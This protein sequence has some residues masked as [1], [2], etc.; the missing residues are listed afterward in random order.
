MV[1]ARKQG[2]EGMARLLLKVCWNK[3]ELTMTFTVVHPEPPPPLA[4]AGQSVFSGRDSYSLILD[5]AGVVRA[6]GGPA[7]EAERTRLLLGQD[8]LRQ[9]RTFPC[10]KAEIAAVV[11]QGVRDL[12]A[13]RRHQ[14]ACDHEC[15][16]NPG[17]PC[18]RITGVRLDG[19]AGP[20][21]FVQ[22]ENVSEAKRN[23]RDLSLARFT[24][25]H[26]ADAIF[27]AGESGGFEYVNDQACA[28]LGY[29]A[30]ELLKLSVWDVDTSMTRD[31]WKTAWEKCRTES[32][33]L[34][35]SSSRSRDGRLLP[36]EVTV[37]HLVSGGKEFHC[38]YVRDISARRALEAQFRQAQKLEAV[39]RLA[40]GVAHDFN[41]LLTVISGYGDLLL[42]RAELRESDRSLLQ[43]ML[44]AAGRAAGLTK[45]LLLFSR[46]QL[47]QPAVIGLNPLLKQMGA[48]L[49]R[50]MG[51]DVTIELKDAA[52]LGPIKAD[53]GQV[54]QIV[55]NL[56][57]NARDAMPSGGHLTLET[58]N[59]SVAEDGIPGPKRLPAGS[60][61]V[62]RV[63][64]NGAG[65]DEATL[66][67]LYEPF[68]TTKEAGKGT[69][70]GLSTV[71][72][73]VKQAGGHIFCHSEVGKGTSFTLLFPRCGEPAANAAPSGAEAKAGGHG[74]VLLVEDDANVRMLARLSLVGHGYAVIEA[75]QGSEAIRKAREKDFAFDAI[76][77]DMVMPFMNGMDVIRQIRS[78]KPGLPALLMTGY[79]D[80]GISEADLRKEEIIFMQKPFQSADLLARVREAMKKPASPPAGQ[81]A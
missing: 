77:T 13:G 71:Y 12:L 20:L 65:M 74:T 81:A 31:L 28:M 32:V 16:R 10:P 38:A 68:F 33:L 54:E 60:W 37:K 2:V 19:P 23:E 24:L 3:E 17:R 72:G 43:E 63:R 80:A 55:M 14:F 46:K 26:A 6:L 67:H 45:Q 42:E 8:Y 21:V 50:L 66:S 52:D 53:P 1:F 57:L 7:A 75:A 29:S 40:G 59:M 22:H 5:A 73:I 79:L 25:D 48:M 78:R 61:T 4:C 11:E 18:F 15:V 39:G 76:V 30:E 58:A 70:L 51:E 64:D 56:A 35:E 69:G 47:I 41:N 9:V 36:V 34:L 44:A 62:L 49:R 27:W